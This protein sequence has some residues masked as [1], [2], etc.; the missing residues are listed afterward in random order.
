VSVTYRP[1]S[2]AAGFIPADVTSRCNLPRRA[3]QA[4]SIRWLRHRRGFGT[5]S[6]FSVPLWWVCHRRGGRAAA[7]FLQT[8]EKKSCIAA[9]RDYNY[10]VRI[11]GQT[12][13]FCFQTE[14]TTLFG[15]RG[16][17]VEIEDAGKC[18]KVLKFE[19]PTEQVK[20]K[21]EDKYGKL[22]KEAEMPG[23]RR[24]HVPRKL[25]ERRLGKRIET[26]IKE[27]MM[28]KALDET[29][30]KHKLN[31]LGELE[32]PK[33][34]D[35]S[36]DASAPFKF[37]V[38]VMV[39]PDVN[40]TDYIGVELEI[41]EA[42]ATDEDVENE[43]ERLRKETAEL[44]V[45]EGRPVALSDVLICSITL[46]CEGI[47]AFKS[48][49]A[50]LSAA[51]KGLLG[52]EIPELSSKL[53]GRN[54]GDSVEVSFVLQHTNSLR[55]KKNFVG[56]TATA[57]IKINEIKEMKKPE[58]TDQWA[59]SIGFEGLEQLKSKL[60]DNILTNKKALWE[61]AAKEIITMKIIQKTQFDVPSELIAKR[62]DELAAYR[63]FRLASAGI[64]Q[65][66]IDAEAQK[67]HERTM[68][69]IEY[70]FREDLIVA[71]IAE[72]ENIFVTE[73]EVDAEIAAIARERG[74]S[75]TQLMEQLEGENIL[76]HFRQDMLA[77]KVKTFL[78]EKANVKVLPPGSL[79]KRA[80]EKD[81]SPAPSGT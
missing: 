75:E 72:M 33:A 22:L 51:S 64:E 7:P 76:E 38:T 78:R 56:K 8:G 34:Q 16:V 57:T 80:Q 70:K 17:Q 58:A 27:E 13:L 63:A 66:K 43:I 20:E 6:A 47:E 18:K 23:F 46:T 35:I 52:I 54:R 4:L 39:R 2:K 62:A 29:I 45:V 71:K 77:K 3:P 68:Q 50:Y 81:D 11:L 1:N 30:E 10:L 21:I 31:L 40:V 25:L 41:E 36:L 28:S 32:L 26:E 74:V 42:T 65:T 69:E 55:L 14:I 53:E 19:I 9:K 73:E 5:F 37:Q 24:G 49:N 67:Y 12:R 44:T 79:K 15:R 60:R 48:E 59:K 61:S